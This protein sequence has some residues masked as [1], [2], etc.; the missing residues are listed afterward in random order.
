MPGIMYL[1]T[2]TYSETQNNVS[3]LVFV[4]LLLVFSKSMGRLRVWDDD[5]YEYLSI[6]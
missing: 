5:C 4:L 3:V 1:H 6:K 2:R